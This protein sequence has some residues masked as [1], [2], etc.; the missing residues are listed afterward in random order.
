MKIIQIRHAIHILVQRHAIRTSGEIQHILKCWILSFVL[1][2][3][4]PVVYHQ[5]QQPSFAHPVC[6]TDSTMTSVFRKSE[7]LLYMDV[8]PLSCEA[9][10]RCSLLKRDIE[11]LKITQNIIFLKY[12]V[13]SWDFNICAKGNKRKEFHLLHDF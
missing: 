12:W 9:T 4:K 7:A 1:V 6:C 3:F 11:R 8:W 10:D 13:I 5:K 2:F